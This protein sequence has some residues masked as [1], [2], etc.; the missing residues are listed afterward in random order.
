[1]TEAE[2]LACNDPMRMLYLLGDQV[3]ERKRRLFACACCRLVQPYAQHAGYRR[4]LET[5]ERFAD[6]QATAAELRRACSISHPANPGP[7]SLWLAEAIASLEPRFGNEILYVPGHAAR[8]H[9]DLNG[10]SDWSAATCTQAQVLRDLTG[11]LYHQVAINPNSLP[12]HAGVTP[13]QLA[14]V[15]YEDGAFHELPVLADVLEE[16]GCA[17]E[18]I[19]D[20]CRSP[21]PHFRGCWLL[22]LILAKE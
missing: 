11:H 20:H 16:A 7:G 8:A 14:E 5:A 10:A 6:G 15:I 21:G 9:R 13:R 12:S 17:D 22:D 4:P 2:W 18:C 19:L 3:S 1:M